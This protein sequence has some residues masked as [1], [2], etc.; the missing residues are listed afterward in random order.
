MLWGEENNNNNESGTD[1]KSGENN[2]EQKERGS[3]VACDFYNSGGLMQL[4]DED[5]VALLMGRRPGNTPFQYILST[6]LLIP[7]ST[8]PVNT[9]A[10]ISFQYTLS[11]PLSTYPYPENASYKLTLSMHPIIPP[12]QTTQLTHPFN[13]PVNTPIS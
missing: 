2:V 1:E 3:V 10:N 4:S 8:H 5:I 9:P 12:Y 11:I 7:L 13:A 6:P